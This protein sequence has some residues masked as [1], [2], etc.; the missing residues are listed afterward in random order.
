VEQAAA[1]RARITNI[2]N[3]NAKDWHT[4]VVILN[5]VKGLAVRFFATLRMTGLSSRA[6]KCTNVMPSD[7]AP[8]LL[9][10]FTEGVVIL[11][12]KI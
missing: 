7:L 3:Q 8:A 9:V 12:K 11:I 5:E 2:L 10:I 1:K 6:V 4:R